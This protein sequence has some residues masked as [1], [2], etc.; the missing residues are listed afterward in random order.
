ML[1][2]FFLQL[3]LSLKHSAELQE[4]HLSREAE[5]G[6]NACMLTIGHVHYHLEIQGTKENNLPVSKLVVGTP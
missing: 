2:I 3:H 5:I 6:G 4:L 1:L